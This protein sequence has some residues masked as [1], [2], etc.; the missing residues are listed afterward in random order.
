MPDL[1]S[2]L[3]IAATVYVAAATVFI[4]SENRRPQ[5]SFAWLFLFITLPVLAPVLYI[6]FGR[7]RGGVGRTRT[8]TRHDLPGHLAQSLDRVEAEHERAL[9]DLA[10][11]PFP[12]V[13][14][15][16]LVYSSAQV[17]VSLSNRVEILQNASGKYPRLMDDLRAARSSIHL[18]YY[19]WENDGVSA[20]FEAI[21]AERAAAGVEVRLLYDPVGSIGRF[22]PFRRR[23]L[24]DKGIDARP[25]SPLWRV[26][27]ISYRNHRK[28]AVIDGR[29]GY[30]GGLNIGDQHFDPGPRFDHWRD[31][32]LRLEGAAVL[33]L[34]GVFAID[35]SNAT[36]EQILGPDYFP[37]L[38]DGP[39]DGLPV[40]L[41]L[42]GPDSQ[43]RAVRQQYFAMI[44]GARRRVRVQTPFFIL[45]E[46]VMEALK[47]AALAGIDVSVMISA[48]GPGQY[49]PYWAANT[50][51]AEAAE[52]GVEVLLYQG[53]Y[54]HAKTVTVDGEI[55]SV[56][57]GN[58]DIRSFSINYELNA[59]IYDAGVAAELEAAFDADRNLC[60]AFDAAAYR[61]SPPL[62]RLRDS[63]ARL[64]SPLM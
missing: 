19:I 2:L 39:Q 51:K 55:A 43:W 41:C 5:S 7:M 37:A 57:S 40:Q 28:I 59:L 4:V 8:L 56:G 50:F 54:L 33:A 27:T 12:R 62:R 26:H 60:L 9:E 23:A 63:A 6:L 15:A 18:Q 22:G 3:S 14:L 17:Y 49:L 61:A 48:E 25:Y 1:A 11:R 53:G 16:R 44:V 24:R 35:W 42:S 32:H 47:A 46:T 20:E 34:Q 58:W 31:T 13:R 10:T 45:D 38:A 36:R 29:V 21:L 30:T 64:I 52:A